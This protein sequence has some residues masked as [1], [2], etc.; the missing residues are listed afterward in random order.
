MDNRYLMGYQD[1][2]HGGYKVF[3]A[4]MRKDSKP[5]DELR[6]ENIVKLRT[7][8]DFEN[9]DDLKCMADCLNDMVERWGDKDV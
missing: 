8:L 6:I 3:D 2:I 9:I 5:D 7:V 1:I 4:V